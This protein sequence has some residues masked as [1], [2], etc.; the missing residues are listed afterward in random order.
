M[1]FNMP[2][3]DEKLDNILEELTKLQGN[4]FGDIFI[5]QAGCM[6]ISAQQRILENLNKD[7]IT[8]YNILFE[9]ILELKQLI[10]PMLDNSLFSQ[11]KTLDASH[12]QNIVLPLF[13]SAWTQYTEET[14]DHSLDLVKSRLTRS[15]F[16]KN[17]FAGKSCF[18]GGC[19]T[20][21]LSIAMSLLGATKVVA[22]DIGKQ[23]LDFMEAH[24]KRHGANVLPH[25]C[26]ITDLE[27]FGAD[28]FDF[29]ASY[30]VLHHTERML[31]GLKEH[32]RILK[33]GG[34]LWLY[35]YGSGGVY[36]YIYD[37]FRDLMRI[38]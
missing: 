23:S 35:L 12:T 34:Y 21:R 5:F 27:V 24:A 38:L 28:T 25:Q 20:G 29:V 33:P 14:F 15:G 1:S 4:R 22:A 3:L 8:S 19:G 7:P 37:K 16:D 10:K 18:D 31:Y 36:W 26:D 32:M 6:I 13:E 11:A 30:G 2:E 17:Y 9:S